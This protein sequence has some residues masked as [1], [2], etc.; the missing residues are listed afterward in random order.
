MNTRNTNVIENEILSI[1]TSD[2][3]SD[4]MRKCNENFATI[5]RWGGGPDGVEG[6]KGKQGVPTKPKVPIHIWKEGHEYRSESTPIGKEPTIV[7]LYEDLSD[8]KYQEGHLIMLQNAHVYILELNNFELKPKYI[9][10]MQSYDPPTVINGKSANIF[11]AYANSSDGTKDFIL[12]D[13]LNNNNENVKTYTYMGVYG[14]HRES[15]PIAKESYL[16]KWVRIQGGIGETEPQGTQST[17]T[18]RYVDDVDSNTLLKITPEYSWYN[19]GLET[20]SL[21]ITENLYN[22][23]FKI[24]PRTLD[25]TTLSVKNQNSIFI[26][27]TITSSSSIELTYGYLYTLFIDPNR[28][29]YI[30]YS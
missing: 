27:K 25:G 9:F 4:F 6:E 21:N 13:D 29:V 7:D 18:H 8:P 15:A 12:A 17:H 26:D 14:G 22:M 24:F 3:I 2:T 1:T 16:Y 28:N 11:F 5:V 30:F 10:A 23:E 19:V 20:I